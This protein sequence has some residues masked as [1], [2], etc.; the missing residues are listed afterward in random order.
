VAKPVLLTFDDDPQVL[1]ANVTK[2]GVSAA[3]GEG[4]AAVAMF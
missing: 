2:H 4:N 1:N 3:T